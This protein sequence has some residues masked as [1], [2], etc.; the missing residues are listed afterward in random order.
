MLIS[1][2]FFLSKFNTQALRYIVLSFF[3]VFFVCTVN[4]KNV[5]H[6]FKHLTA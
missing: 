4:S 2:V 3:P 1:T 6:N 5:T